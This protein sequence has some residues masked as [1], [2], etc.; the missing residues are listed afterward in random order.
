MGWIEHH[1]VQ[2]GYQ[3]A[4]ITAT[5]TYCFTVS[6]L[7][8]FL[9]N[10]VPGLSLRSS[11]EDEEVGMDECQVGEFAYDYVE[12]TRHVADSGSVITMPMAGETVATSSSSFTTEKRGP[13]PAVV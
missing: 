1:W 9:I 3:L 13:E 5:F 10:L 4:A 6:C 7:L 8:L 2:V 11:I 12:L